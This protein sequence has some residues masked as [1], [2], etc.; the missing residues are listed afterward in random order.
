MKFAF[1]FLTSCLLINPA[2]AENPFSANDLSILFPM[3]DETKMKHAVSLNTEEWP[4]VSSETFKQVLAG[5]EEQGVFL[6]AKLRDGNN[7]ALVALRYTPCNNLAGVT[8]N[9]IEQIRFCLSTL[10]RSRIA[11]WC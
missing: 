7:W 2:I 10:K 8:L 11:H 5:A 9:C 6:N 1:F 3:A 4:V